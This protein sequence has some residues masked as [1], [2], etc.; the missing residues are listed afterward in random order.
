MGLART[1]ARSMRGGLLL[2]TL[3]AFLPA[4]TLAQTHSGNIVPFAKDGVQGVYVFESSG[5]RLY[6]R[7]VSDASIGVWE[8]HGRPPLRRQEAF[9]GSVGQ[10]AILSYATML[11]FGSSQP[12]LQVFVVRNGALYSR[13]W[14]GSAW[15]WLSYGAPPMRFLF[16]EA[17]AVVTHLEADGL[18]RRIVAYCRDT[19]GEL[20]KMSHTSS[21]TTWT[22]LGHPPLPRHP[23]ASF[24]NTGAEAV[25]F[26]EDGTRHTY[27]FAAS[28]NEQLYVNYSDGSTHQWVNQ[29][30]TTHT[31]PG[32][33]AFDDGS[34]S[35]AGVDRSI[36]VFVPQFNASHGLG[37]H[38]KNAGAWQWADP[39]GP[40]VVGPPHA[41]TFRHNGYRNIWAF[42]AVPT[43][44][45]GSRLWVNVWDGFEWSWNDRSTPWGPQESVR[46]AGAATYTLGG[47]RRLAA[48]ARTDTTGDLWLNSFASGLWSWVN[49]G[50]P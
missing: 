25:T 32:V 37:V 34:T 4:V 33:V 31:R 15:S 20:H 7:F 21:Q 50:Q 39:E 41:I 14:D 46:A 49:L 11:L 5:A 40:E 42:I 30:V 27:V 13:Y 9:Y 10:P 6:G 38:Y 2:A 35:S 24:L 36:Y 17:P 22:F 26:T 18:T 16:S 8:D 19:D 45:I 43:E 1:Q 48:V 47:E 29:D 23:I 28:R 12:R 3:L 44:G